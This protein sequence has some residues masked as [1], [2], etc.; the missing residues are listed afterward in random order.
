MTEFICD[1]NKMVIMT[2]Y[3]N[4]LLELYNDD[5]YYDD[6]PTVCVMFI[7]T[8]C[9]SMQVCLAFLLFFQ[10]QFLSNHHDP[11]S[12]DHHLCLPVPFSH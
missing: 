12:C 8:V 9:I 2:M 7:C 1:I 11:C 6:D 10:I 4:E 3:I 5:G